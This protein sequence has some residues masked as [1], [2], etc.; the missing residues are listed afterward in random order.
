MIFLLLSMIVVTPPPNVPECR[1]P[2]PPGSGICSFK[3]G[4][5]IICLP[6]CTPEEKPTS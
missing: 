2:D 1:E 4:E 5:H 3:R 6:R